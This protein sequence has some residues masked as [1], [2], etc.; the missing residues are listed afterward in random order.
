M[1]IILERIWSVLCRRGLPLL[2]VVSLALMTGCAQLPLGNPTASF[3]NIEKANVSRTAPVA[4]G[5]F[6][7][8][9]RVN[10]EIDKGLSVRSNTIFS[11]FE[12]SFAQ[13]LRQTLITDLQAAGLYDAAA[14]TTLSGFLTESTLDAP[15]GTGH[16]SLSARFIL[17]RT[18]KTIYEKELKASVT[19]PS[20]F[21]GVEAIPAGMNQYTSLY[22]QLVGK[23]L[24]DPDYRSANSK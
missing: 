14:Q 21:I 9:P 24:D 3:E 23:L 13:Y 12:G 7:I 4:V 17:I 8:G 18:G 15:I 16:A 20:A 5:A 1:P 2:A 22:H 11:P 19:W 6:K 10:A